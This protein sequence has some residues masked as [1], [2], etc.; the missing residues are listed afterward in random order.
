MHVLEFG[1]HKGKELSDVPRAYLVWMVKQGTFSL[2]LHNE[3]CDLLGW[4]SMRKTNKPQPTQPQHRRTP[5]E[6]KEPDIVIGADET[7]ID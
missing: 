5:W 2:S 1:K 4:Q 7:R 3:V 6:P